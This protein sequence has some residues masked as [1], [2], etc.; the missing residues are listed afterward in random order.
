LLQRLQELYDQGYK[1]LPIVFME[2]I[3]ECHQRH[4]SGIGAGRVA[5]TYIAR[6]CTHMPS[7][8][9]M[10]LALHHH[11]V[12]TKSTTSLQTSTLE[13][14][15]RSSITNPVLLKKTCCLHRTA[16]RL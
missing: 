15:Y 6:R 4:A 9:Q 14:V 13:L 16:G 3:K 2:E 1:D 7:T 12:A 5:R 10:A 11:K 8:F